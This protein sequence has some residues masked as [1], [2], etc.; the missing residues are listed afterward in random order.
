M[1]YHCQPGSNGSG[2]PS[3]SAALDVDAV[4]TS[5]TAGVV[6]LTVTVPVGASLA[7]VT[8][9]TSWSSVPSVPSEAVT[10]TTYSLLAAAFAGAALATSTGDS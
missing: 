2:R 7:L 9:T 8:A 10:N 3:W 5:P 6:S 4:N 1:R